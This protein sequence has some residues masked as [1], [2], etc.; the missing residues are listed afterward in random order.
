MKKEKQEP[1]N[2]IKAKVNRIYKNFGLET[3][4]MED[5]ESSLD[6]VYEF[7]DKNREQLEIDLAASEQHA[8]KFEDEDLL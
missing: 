8:E 1:S 5:E 6:A 4:F 7:Y 2:K 3:T